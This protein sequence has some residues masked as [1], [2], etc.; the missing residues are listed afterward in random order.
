MEESQKKAAPLLEWKRKEEYLHGY[1]YPTFESNDELWCY[2]VYPLVRPKNPNAVGFHFGGWAKKSASSS[3][4]KMIEGTAE[5]AEEC[6]AICLA[7]ATHMQSI[8]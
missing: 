1:Y 6:K 8:E 3:K 2:S 7:H 4:R 5:T